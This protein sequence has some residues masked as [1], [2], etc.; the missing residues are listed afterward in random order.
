MRP[1]ALTDVTPQARSINWSAFPPRPHFG[2][3]RLTHGASAR[4]PCARWHLQLVVAEHYAVA[5]P[6]PRRRGVACQQ[7]VRERRETVERTTVAREAPVHV[8]VIVA[9]SGATTATIAGATIAASSTAVRRRVRVCRGDQPPQ[10]CARCCI[11]TCA[12]RRGHRLDRE[13]GRVLAAARRVE[14]RVSTVVADSNQTKLC[15]Y[16]S[17]ILLAGLVLNATV[18]WSASSVRALDATADAVIGSFAT[19]RRDFV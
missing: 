13:C 15:A 4:V 1:G 8:A 2:Q 18:G 6:G 10:R 9:G 16:L 7:F 11:H 14:G 12:D 17:A 19:V 5:L 3:S